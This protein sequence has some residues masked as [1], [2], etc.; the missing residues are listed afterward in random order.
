M[1]LSPYAEVLEPDFAAG[2]IGLLVT[3]DSYRPELYNVLEISAYWAA[4]NG[5]FNQGDRFDLEGYLSWLESFPLEAREWCLFATAPDV[6]GDWEATLE[7]SLPV[8]EE[9]RYMGY[10]A[11]I[12]LQNGATAE[13]VP[14]DL[15]DVVFVGGST[16]WKLGP[17]AKAL[18]RE[19][20]RRSK[21]VHVGRVNSIKR[22]RL[23]ADIADTAD[24]TLIIFGPNANQGRVRKTSAALGFGNFYG[25]HGLS[26]G[27]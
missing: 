21:L 3:P 23:V 8:L 7:R 16:E 22:A 24:G 25:W 6:V 10:P 19:A 5:C 13:T 18:C 12:V 4:D 2:R 27:F 20:R 9:I 14:W 26:V 15:I 17:E 1:Y 11:A